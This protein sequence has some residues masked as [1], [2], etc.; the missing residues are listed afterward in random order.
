MTYRLHA[1]LTR[2]VGSFCRHP[3]PSSGGPLAMLR[4]IIAWL[5]RHEDPYAEPWGEVATGVPFAMGATGPH[6][7]PICG[8]ACTQWAAR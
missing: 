5:R 3:I 4:R 7:C 1:L 8:A 6:R 2:V